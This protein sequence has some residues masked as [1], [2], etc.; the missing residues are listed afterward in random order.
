MSTLRYAIRVGSDNENE[1]GGSRRRCG[2]PSG[3]PTRDDGGPARGIVCPS[4]YVP[5]IEEIIEATKK[6]VRAEHLLGCTGAGIIGT[7]R[8]VEEKPALSLLVGELPSVTIYP[9]HLAEEDLE[10]S[11]GA[12]FWHYQL[13]L[14]PSGQ[15]QF[16]LL[17][18]PFTTRAMQLVD[19]LADAYPQAPMIGGLASGAQQAGENRLFVNGK[20]YDE[21]AVGIGLTGRVS[22]GPSCRR[23]VDRSANR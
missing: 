15:P 17:V 4:G 5:H 13:E 7:D 10:E 8:E 21:G 23:G 19:A 22:P 18:D 1:L 12:A 2:A 9:F 6:A 14:E 11:T 3:F 16:V 20:L